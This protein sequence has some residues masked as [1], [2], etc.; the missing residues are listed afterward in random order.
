MSNFI[1]RFS[2]FLTGFRNYETIRFLLISA[3][4]PFPS[5]LPHYDEV[6]VHCP[7]N[8]CC[9]H[10]SFGNHGTCNQLCSSV[11]CNC[12]CLHLP[13]WCWDPPQVPAPIQFQVWGKELWLLC[14]C[15]QQLP[16]LPHLLANWKWC[17]WSYWDRSLELH[18]WQPDHL[19]PG[20][21][22]LQPW[23]WCFPLCWSSNPLWCCWVWKDWC[24]SF[25]NLK[26]FHHYL[27]TVMEIK[28][29]EDLIFYVAIYF[30]ILSFCLISSVWF[31]SS[32]LL[33]QLI[34]H[35]S[36]KE[37][38]FLLFCFIYFI[39]LKWLLIGTGSVK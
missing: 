28:I 38:P 4:I 32:F 10:C 23:G 1:G 6:Q 21:P 25:Q 27:N 31:P 24:L 12:P 18:L 26:Q 33:Y 8:H 20:Y 9:K 30:S 7:P 35:I 3:N 5:N 37:L 11:S 34:C 39:M 2:A 17:W 15:W 19:W 13:S 14:W 22:D 16:G 29:C 36:L